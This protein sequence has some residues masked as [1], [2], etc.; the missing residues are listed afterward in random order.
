MLRSLVLALAIV[1]LGAAHIVL[2]YPGTRGNNL[3]TNESFPYGMQWMYPCGGLATTTNRT[4]WPT[5]GGAVAFQPGWF[6]GHQL[7]NLHINLGLG[8][9][10]PDGGPPN[11]SYTMLRDVQLVGPSNTPYPGTVCFP[12]VPMPVN[13]SVKA[14]DRATIQVVEQAQHGAALYACVDIEFAEPGDPKVA[15]VN[16]SNCFNSTDFGFADIYTVTVVEA[17]DRSNSQASHAVAVSI[18]RHLWLA[19]TLVSLSVMLA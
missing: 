3:I 19:M 2:S 5:T 14:G 12:Q 8:T 1:S 13:V 4:Y 7:A 6:Q 16:E 11:M 15:R 9:D 17:P 10:G 18:A